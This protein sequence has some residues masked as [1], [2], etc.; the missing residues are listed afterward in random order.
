MLRRALFRLLLVTVVLL[1]IG[2]GTRFPGSLDVTRAGDHSLGAGALDALAALQ[3]PWQITAYVA[4]LPVQRAELERL[5][6]PYRAHPRA[7]SVVVVDPVARPDIAREAGVSRPI[8][9]HIDSGARH[10]VVTALSPDSVEQALQRLA[11]RGERWIVNLAGHGE[12]ATDA[13][14]AGLG[15]LAA[16]LERRG[17]RVVTIDPLATGTLPRNAAVVIA[18]APTTDYPAA[19]EDLLQAHVDRGGGLLW[20]FDEVFPAWVIDAVGVTPLPG[21]VVDAAAAEVGAQTP[22]HAVVTRLPAPLDVGGAWRHAVLYRARGIDVQTL[23]GWRLAGTVESTPRSW[24]ET[25]ALRGTVQRDSDLGERPGPITVGALWEQEGSGETGRLAL[26][27][28]ADWLANTQ[29]GSG[30]NQALALGL[31]RWLSDNPVPAAIDDGGLAL[32]WSPRTPGHLALLLMY[33]LPAAYL[34]AGIVIR[35]RRRRR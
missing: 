30:D 11:L 19:L 1:A 9:L 26:I 20:L 18:A 22:D 5:L 14:P 24:N 13:A 27:G 35:L 15:R 2:V 29:L 33:L 31:V 28:G 23:A 17:Y 34:A 8:E 25:G 10:E 32:R 7:P 12:R 21:I 16:S 4:D 3:E 6:A